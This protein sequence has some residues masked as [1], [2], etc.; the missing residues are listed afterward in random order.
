MR[1]RRHNRRAMALAAV[2]LVMAVL[3]VAVIGVVVGGG[4]DSRIAAMRAS[5]IRAF[6]AA[7]SGIHVSVTEFSAGRTPP[8]GPITLPDGASYTATLSG[9]TLPADITVVGTCDEANRVITVE[10]E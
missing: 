5:T 2:I 7:E 10:I 1:H 3:N 4:D 9:S 6:L 8:V